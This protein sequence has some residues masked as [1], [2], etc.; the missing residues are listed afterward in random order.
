[1]KDLQGAMSE[2]EAARMG[3]A[4]ESDESAYFERFEGTGNGGDE[5]KG[6]SVASSVDVMRET[7]RATTRTTAR[8]FEL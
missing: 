1:M 3:G 6:V 2:E 5:G 4:G 7:T 8:S